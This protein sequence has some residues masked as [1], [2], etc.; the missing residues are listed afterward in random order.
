MAIN[1]ILAI[2][3]CLS[4]YNFFLNYFIFVTKWM[5]CEI[6][7]QYLTFWYLTFPSHGIVRHDHIRWIIHYTLHVYMT[8]RLHVTCCSWKDIM[9][10]H[11]CAFVWCLDNNINNIFI[12]KIDVFKWIKRNSWLTRFLQYIKSK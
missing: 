4:N 5:F 1:S 3:K 10:C 2:S 11:V 7:L 6:K 9:T 8:N 12:T